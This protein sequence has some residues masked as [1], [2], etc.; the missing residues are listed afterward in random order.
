[1]LNKEAIGRNIVTRRKLQGLTQKELADALHVSYQAVSQWESGKSLPTVEMLYDLAIIL[2][3]TMESLLS[4]VTMANR[5]I[6]YMDSGLDVGKLY[7]VKQKVHEL[8]S[9]DESI[10]RARFMEPLFFKVD[11]SQMK[12]PVYVTATFVPGSKARLA[13]E[14]GFDKEICVDLVARAI[15]NMCCKGV[16][17]LV[18][19]AHLVG[20]NMDGDLLYEMAKSFKETCEK[21]GVKCGVMAIGSQPVNFRPGEYELSAGI[22]GV[23]DEEKINFGESVKAGD[24]LIALKTDGIDTVSYPYTRVM[25]DRKPELRYA[26]IDKEHTFIEELLKPNA[27]YN[28]VIE[29]LDKEGLVHAAFRVSNSFIK[30]MAYWGLPDSL[31]ARIDLEKVKIPPL[32]RFIEKQ[33]MIGRNHIPY[34]FSMGVGMIVA[35]PKERTEDAL[36]LICRYHDCYVIG[37][38]EENTDNREEKVRA[39]GTVNWD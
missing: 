19:Q 26:K 23:C 8:I 27:A 38:I 21:N 3:V 15:N 16:K 30:D 24:V 17:P 2:D 14:Q 37:A 7:V 10:V 4:D 22:I 1:M 11:T 39:V 9:K 6:N 13:R 18:F 28:L 25:F 31:T 5:D 34:R 29:E 36:N 33:D 35:V 32:F 12:N 20:G